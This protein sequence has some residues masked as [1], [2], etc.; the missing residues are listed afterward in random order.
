MENLNVNVE[1]EITSLLW[2][3]E[4]PNSLNI[5][6]KAI[7]FKKGIPLPSD[8]YSLLNKCIMLSNGTVDCRGFKAWQAVG[9]KCIKGNYF[10]ILAPN[11]VRIRDKQDIDKF[12]VICVGFRPIMVW[13]YEGTEGE[14]IDY[15][16]DRE[17]PELKLMN[18]AKKLGLTVSQTF[19]NSGFKGYYNPE[20]KEIILATDDQKTF[21]HELV[22]AV[23]DKLKKDATGKGL[24]EGKVDT[25]EIIAE[26]S[27]VVLCNILGLKVNENEAF[28]YIEEYSKKTKKKSIR[29]I[30]SVLPKI[31]KIINYILVLNEQEELQGV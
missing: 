11:V 30:A 5:I 4:Q 25:Q 7:M 17:L 14:P 8:N 1:K 16:L 19:Q 2:K 27:A 29:S 3:F 18:V 15:K 31:Q 12:K 6:S 23:H 13:P 20:R 26:F 10:F 9:R 22:N 28:H 21:C 24:K